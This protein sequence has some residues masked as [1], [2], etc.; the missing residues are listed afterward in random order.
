M[1]RTLRLSALTA[2]GL[3]LGLSLQGCILAAGAAAGAA[4]GYEAKKH[5]Y[6]VQS[7]VKKDSAGGIK[8]QAPVVKHPQDDSMSSGNS[9]NTTGSSTGQS[10]DSS[11][12]QTTPYRDGYNNNGSTVNGG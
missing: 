3:T 11:N 6:D 12:G 8:G 5:G 9:A 10:N 2:A 1:N 7:P 4:G